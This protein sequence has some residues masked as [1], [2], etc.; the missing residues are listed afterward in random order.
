MKGLFDLRSAE[1][2]YEKL[3]ADYDRVIDDPLDS[4]AAFDFVVTAWHLLEWRYPGEDARAKLARNE[5]CERHP[6]LRACHHLAIGAKHFEP[7]S[8]KLDSGRETH[9]TGPFGLRMGSWARG[10]WAEDAWATYLVVKLDG[11]ARTEFGDQ[12]RIEQL[13]DLTMDAWRSEFEELEG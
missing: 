9:R 12:M 7:T 13:A 2:L 11:P 5:V 3:K 8:K 1:D 10:A 6:I 4:H